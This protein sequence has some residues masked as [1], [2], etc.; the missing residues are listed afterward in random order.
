M[1]EFKDKKVMVVGMAMSGISAAKMLLEEGAEVTLYDAK[2]ASNFN[3]GD[4]AERCTLAFEADAME[5]MRANDMLVLSPGVPTRLPFIKEAQAVKPV[6][7]E[8]ELGYRG[9]KADFVCISGTNGKTTTT[10]LTGEIFKNG[11]KKTYVLGN[12]GV[13]I[14]EHALE[15]EEGDVIVAETA[16]LQLETIDRF[17]ARAGALLNL[18]EDHMDRFGTMEYYSE[19]KMR[20]FENMTEDDF[21]IFNAEDELCRKYAATLTRPNVLWFDASGNECE[22][23]YIEN[24]N[25]IYKYKGVKTV[26]CPREDLGIP[27]KHNLENALAAVCLAMSMGIDAESIAETL[28]TFPGVEHRLEYV[29]TRGGVRFVN[30]SKGTNVDATQKAIEAMSGPTVLIL[31][32]YDKHCTFEALFE[33]FTENIKGAVML[34]ATR[35]KLAENA[36]EAGFTNFV[37]ADTFEEAV[38]K[39]YEMAA[40]EGTVL[41]SPACASW[42][43][44]KNFEQRGEIFK[45]IARGIAE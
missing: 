1:S 37:M 11:G 12:I 9:A 19:C 22:G 5:V 20:L 3:L 24:G 4:L 41:L 34:G 18:T 40:G 38:L 28:R 14:T 42:D 44:F 13:P 43:M 33:A 36:R 25:I 10:A 35:D 23:A 8:I 31:G 17:H 21:A 6:I 45:D 26:I 39:A 7:A 16:A 30:D 32:G 15:T 27:G 29:C 2:P